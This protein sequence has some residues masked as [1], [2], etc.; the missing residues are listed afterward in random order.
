MYSQLRICKRY[1][2][3]NKL[4]SWKFKY[5]PDLVDLLV[6]LS[7]RRAARRLQGGQLGVLIDSN[8]LGHSITHETV[9][10]STGPKKWGDSYIDTGYAARVC[11]YGPDADSD[12]YKNVM[13]LPGIASLAREGL[14]I[15]YT[16][17]EL[18]DEQDRQPIGRFRGYGLFDRGL[19][20]NVDI[21]SIDGYAF[22]AAGSIWSGRPSAREQQQS[23]LKNRESD[24]LYIA[25]IE[26]MGR[27][28]NLDAWHI[29]TAERHNLFCF[30]T[31]DF[32]LRRIVDANLH[33]EPFRSM[34][35]RVMTP[36]E[37]GEFLGLQPIRPALFS[38]HD[39]S[40]FVRPDLHHSDN[41]RRPLRS[42]RRRSDKDV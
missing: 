23:R 19:L 30:L 37:L 1:I 35:T 26:Q 32:K 29:C 2:L 12:V 28:N 24:P 20:Q 27:K 42:Y 39:A 10:V 41:I 16:S 7:T 6:Y 36:A 8:V 38:Y 18:R 31:M 13:F 21:K 4:K 34:R 17:A 14:I 33:K 25:L 5:F 11:V 15:F 3:R 40:W 22:P 9:W